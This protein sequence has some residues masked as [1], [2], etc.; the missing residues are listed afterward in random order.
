MRFRADLPALAAAALVAGC[1]GGGGDVK[2]AAAVPKGCEKAVPS[3]QRDLPDGFPEPQ[4]GL[5][6]GGVEQRGD[7]LQVDGVA[8]RSPGT[9]ARDLLAAEGVQKID[10]EDDGDDAEAS[11]TSGTYRYAF[12]FVEACEGGSTFTAVRVREPGS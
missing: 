1:G 12:K 11:F 7:Q 8:A 6:A 2:T 10:S 4:G 9:A 3:S 5:T